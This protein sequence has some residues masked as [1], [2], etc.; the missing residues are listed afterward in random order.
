MNV[1]YKRGNTVLWQQNEWVNEWMNTAQ[2]E[3]IEK[4]KNESMDMAQSEVIEKNEW[5]NEWNDQSEIIEKDL[6]YE[7]MKKWMNE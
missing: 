6:M 1:W 7:W 2:S 3:I 5:S 4:I